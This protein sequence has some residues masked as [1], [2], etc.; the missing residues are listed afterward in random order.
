MRK[1]L[2]VVISAATIAIAACSSSSSTTTPSGTDSG[3]NTHPATDDSGAST[4]TDSGSTSNTDSGTVDALNGCTTYVD[5]TAD[6]V[7][8]LA[9]DFPITSS[10]DHCSKIKVGAKV[11]W[12]GNFGKH[13][14]DPFNGDANNPISSAA[15]D[16]GP[17]VTITF[18]AAGSFGYHCGVHASMLGAI[19]VVP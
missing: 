16:G 1:E 12:T 8:N 17:D 6:A 2:F 13:P 4:D 14:L 5:H 11:K 7:V 15:A 18:P 19:M 10:P 9:W 3:V